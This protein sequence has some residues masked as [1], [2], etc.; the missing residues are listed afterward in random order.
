MSQWIKSLRCVHKDLS[1]DPMYCVKARGIGVCNHDTE[2][3]GPTHDCNHD[4]GVGS[5]KLSQACGCP[6]S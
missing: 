1:S 5:V 6:P 4:T 3:C 2:V